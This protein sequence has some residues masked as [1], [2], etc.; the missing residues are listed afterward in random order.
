[1]FKRPFKLYKINE[2]PKFQPSNPYILSGYRALLTANECLVSLFFLSNEFCNVWSH[3]VGFACFA[4]C[5]IYDQAIAI[6]ASGGGEADK[7]VFLVFHVACQ[8][9]MLFSAFYHT[10]NCH[11]ER[12]VITTFLSMDLLGII[13]AILGCYI[14]GLYYILH[15]HSFLMK[16]YMLISSIVIVGSVPV[17]TSKRY[18]SSEGSFLRALHLSSIVLMGFLP[19]VN[20]L[21]V[22]DTKEISK[23]FPGILNL[24]V[25]LGTALCFFTTKFPE[26]CKPGFF[27]TFGHSHTLWHVMITFALL[28][29]RRFGLNMIEHRSA[30]QCR[31]NTGFNLCMFDSCIF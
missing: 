3:L 19:I 31:N 27:D 30:N 17:V 23:I 11:L 24:Y 21:L 26:V 29:W 10:F 13:S 15:C 5:S 25:L 7:K 22:S 16:L 2:I 4:A 9:C 6:D 28:Y 1:M 12:G 8:L 20:W 18:M 14:V